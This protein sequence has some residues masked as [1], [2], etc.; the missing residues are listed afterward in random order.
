MSYTLDIYRDRLKPSNSI[1]E[2]AIFVAFFPQLVAG[3]IVR[4]VEFLPQLE[5]DIKIKKENF[6]Y[7]IQI[8]ITGFVKKLLIA[9]TL[10]YYVDYVFANSSL[11]NTSTVWLGVIA[12]SIQ[13]FLDFS[14]Y[15]DMAIGVAKCMGY[16]LPQNFRMPYISKNITEFWRRWHITLSFW[17]RDYLYIS[18]GGNRK[19][20]FR[21]DVNLMLTMLLGG[22]WHGAS[23][24]FVV[25]GGLQGA[26]LILH[27]IYMKKVKIIPT[28]ITVAISWIITYGFVCVSWV[29][30]RTQDF[31]VAFTVLRKMF[32]IGDSGVSYYYTAAVILI[33][34][35]IILHI[36]GLIYKFDDKYFFLDLKTQ[37]GAIALVFILFIL[38]Y[39]SPLNTSP[40]IYFQF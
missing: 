3:P 38:Y 33:P 31:T 11:L 14:G 36:V 34:V 20:K 2:F 16:D 9:D 32:F 15:S 1:F 5:D 21:T 17:L 35:V 19:G 40:F 37:K 39:F 24:N 13:I 6:Y 30:F 28:K 23:W 18:L 7:G 27:K 8:F 26:G 4:A 22:L 12:Y 25:W 10:A 29:F